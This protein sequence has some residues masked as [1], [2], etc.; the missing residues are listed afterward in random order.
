MRTPKPQMGN[1]EIFE[2]V[3]EDKHLPNGDPVYY[4][5]YQPGTGLP[6]RNENMTSSLTSLP[7][8]DPPCPPPGYFPRTTSRSSELSPMER[9]DHM[10]ESPNYDPRFSVPHVV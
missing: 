2:T 10:Y 4:K 9:V 5:T 1:M 3:P 6:P 8:P 7:V